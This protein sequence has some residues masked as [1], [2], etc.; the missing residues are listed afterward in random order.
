MEF[1]DKADKFKWLKGSSI[2]IMTN[3]NP[4]DHLKL[5][6]FTAKDRNH[7]I[8]Q[9]HESYEN[10]VLIVNPKER[11]LMVNVVVDGKPDPKVLQNEMDKANDILKTLYKIRYRERQDHYMTFVG[12]II[13]PQ[14]KD[15]DLNSNIFPFLNAPVPTFV[16]EKEWNNNGLENKLKSFINDSKKKIKSQGGVVSR[17]FS[18][19]LQVFTGQ[20][21]TSM[22][23]RSL[24]LPRVTDDQE[25]RISTIFL[26]KAQIEA[27][28]YPCKWKTINGGYGSGK[29]VVLNEI[30]WKM[31]N[32]DDVSVVCYLP[33]V[34]Y[35]LIDQQF[36]KSFRLLCEN[37][38][39]ARL[40]F[41]LKSI[42]LQDCV[43]EMNMD[44]VNFYDFTTPPIK[45]VSFII[46]Y[47]KNKFHSQGKK[48]AILIDE[49]P[50]EFI[51]GSYAKQLAECL[52]EHFQDITVV[53]SYQSIEKVKEYEMDGN[54]V[55]SRETTTKIPGIREFKLTKTMRMALKIFELNEILKKEVAKIKHVTPL[56]YETIP[57]TNLELPVSNP[58]RKLSSTEVTIIGSEPR[59]LVNKVL[60]DNASEEKSSKKII[61]SASKE[62]SSESTLKLDTSRLHDVEILTKL[63]NPNKSRIVHSLNTKISFAKTE[64]GHSLS[65]LRKPKVHWLPDSLNSIESNVC[66]SL[67]LENCIE[68]VQ[69]TAIIC[70]SKDQIET[71]KM[72]L[73]RI[74][75]KKQHSVYIPYL[76]G[77][78]PGRQEK[79]KIIEDSNN[80]D[81]ILLTDYRSFR[82]CESEKCIMLIDLNSN[83]GPNLYVEILTRSVAYLDILVTPRT[84]RTSSDTSKVMDN[85]LKEWKERK[86]AT[87]VYMKIDSKKKQRDCDEIDITI[88]ES[89]TKT[90]ISRKLTLEDRESFQKQMVEIING[91]SDNAMSLQ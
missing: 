72:A 64:C 6:G 3:Y 21:M 36:A 83:I 84:E 17:N 59:E 43:A 18:E 52:N 49:F 38:D 73:D 44:L 63:E 23:Q 68:D 65:C 31:I 8:S 2:K 47:L 74:E 57:S 28:N 20:L 76:L 15:E 4:D 87:Q 54:L 67:V 35:S 39:A 62:I 12:V 14:Y 24:F 27:I 41:K 70:T 46:E 34:P 48:M 37:K 89:E 53:I 25:E 60:K 11:W 75:P 26:N 58:P 85:V 71:M 69:R 29:T 42:C 56:K 90:K 79:I 7:I 55:S 88:C 30:A 50:R 91:K 40:N 82:G 61:S 66:L 86:L 51:D 45:N 78:L 32:E 9:V 13:C 22:A 5:L 33:F 81:F 1:V 19:D 80:T 10:V 16:T 77:P